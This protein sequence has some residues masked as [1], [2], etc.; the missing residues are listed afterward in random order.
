LFVFEFF[1]IS[2]LFEFFFRL[3]K[4][5]LKRKGKEKEKSADGP[6]RLGGACVRRL[7]PRRRR[8]RRGAPPAA[9]PNLISGDKLI[10]P[11]NIL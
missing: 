11:I 10:W 3:K 9:H 5:D 6:A 2:N 8:R 7:L 1:L 4:I